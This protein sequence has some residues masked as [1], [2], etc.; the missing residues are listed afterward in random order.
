M[1]LKFFKKENKHKRIYIINIRIY[2]LIYAGQYILIYSIYIN[3]YIIHKKIYTCIIFTAITYES[4]NWL[5]LSLDKL[6]HWR[7][8]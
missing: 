4:F 5:L 3:L 2:L 7:E 1:T 6:R 8:G